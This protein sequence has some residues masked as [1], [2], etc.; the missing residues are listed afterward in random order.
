MQACA[1]ILQRD[2]PPRV[3]STPRTSTALNERKNLRVEGD[4]RSHP[5]WRDEI[6]ALKATQRLVAIARETG[7]RVHVLHVSTVQE[8]EFLARSQGCGLGRGH[9]ASSHARSARLLRAPRHARADESAGARCRA[10]QWHLGAASNSGVVDVL[11]SDHAP[12]TREEKAK[13]YPASPSG[14]TGVQT[15]VPIMLDHVN[16]GRLSPAAICRSDQR[17]ARYACS[18]SRAKAGLPSATM[19]T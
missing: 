4:P 12:H 1:T 14:M 6:A 13:A 8:M 18:A 19:P 7:A 16:A 3:V 9:A 10:S 17:R 11:G 2:P 5:V 15:L